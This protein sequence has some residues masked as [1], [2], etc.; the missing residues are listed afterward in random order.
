MSQPTMTWYSTGLKINTD[1][2]NGLSLHLS[3]KSPA[4]DIIKKSLFNIKVP[5]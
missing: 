3:V 1:H 5:I 2:F 4:N